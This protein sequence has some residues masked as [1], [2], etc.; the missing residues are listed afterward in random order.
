MKKRARIIAMVLVLV[1]AVGSF[2]GCFTYSIMSGGGGNGELLIFTIALDIVTLPIQIVWLIVT[3]VQK[4]QRDKRGRKMDGIDTFSHT[5]KSLP[6][7]ELSALTQT[8]NSLPKEDVDLLMQK[9]HS[10]PETEIASY[11]QTVN[12]FSETEINAM[13]KAFNG[14]SE[15]EII[16]SLE[17]INSMPEEKVVSMMNNLQHI[18]F[19][20]HK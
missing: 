14:L 10:L 17:T 7:N 5:V 3:Q 19:R 12:S 1:M 11:T 8:I 20:K 16:S 2:T 9:F 18:E 13:I 6:R 4:A 15:E